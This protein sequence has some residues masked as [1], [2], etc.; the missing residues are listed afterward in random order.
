MK[1]KDFV[2]EFIT[3]KVANTKANPNAVAEFINKNIE[4]KT[5]LPF[6][7]KRKVVDIIVSQSIREE[8]GVKKVDSI[9][10]YLS[11]IIA[12][13]GSHTNL[14]LNIENPADDYDSLNS[15]GLLEPIISSF[16]KD[17][18]ECEAL[19]KM[20]IADELSDNNLNVIAGK[21]LNGVLGQ[22]DDLG[23]VL[24]E[25]IKNIDIPKL[26]GDINK[27]DIAK[28]MSFINKSKK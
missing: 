6:Q 16:Q 19:L 8:G 21:F 13:I 24:K 5:Y 4:F 18:A 28:I 9:A 27:E 26:L 14:E 3:K 23:D 7:T 25:T 11:F 22:L 2:N 15:C 12:M 20:A 10:Q 1:I 17:Y